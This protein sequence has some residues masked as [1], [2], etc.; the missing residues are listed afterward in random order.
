[1]TDSD[2]DL[3]LNKYNIAWASVVL[4]ATVVDCEFV[5]VDNISLCDKFLLKK[6]LK[7]KSTTLDILHI[8]PKYIKYNGN[9][10]FA[11]TTCNLSTVS[12]RILQQIIQGKIP[13]KNVDVAQ[14]LVAKNAIN[15]THVSTKWCGVVFKNNEHITLAV[16]LRRHLVAVRDLKDA[17]EILQTFQYLSRSVYIDGDSV[18]ILQE[19]DLA[20]DLHDVSSKLNCARFDSFLVNKDS[21]KYIY[22]PQTF[23]LHN[24]YLFPKYT[25]FTATSLSCFAVLGSL[26]NG[27]VFYQEKRNQALCTNGNNDYSLQN[28]MSLLE[29]QSNKKKMLITL[30]EYKA[31]QSWAQQYS[32]P[33][34]FS[35]FKAAHK[36]QFLHKIA[37][38][39]HGNNLVIIVKL[40]PYAIY[41]NDDKRKT[42]NILQKYSEETSS[43]TKNALAEN[44]DKEF[45]T[46]TEINNQNICL[47]VSLGELS[48]NNQTPAPRSSSQQRTRE[49]AKV[50]RTKYTKITKNCRSKKDK[51]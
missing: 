35:V 14:N 50:L 13:I 10:R 19:K 4:D 12:Q 6:R 51:R 38:E 37:G 48:K 31:T 8:G 32:L 23:F 28:E 34:L 30:S 33:V 36:G 18:T 46:T 29:Q 24:V 2:L 26:Y 5:T 47:N 45:T 20:L 7:Q 49:N 22:H 3:I 1:L 40:S 11:I 25:S 41:K 42:A 9:K 15:D 21:P 17:S 43:M 44:F 27:S 16:Y 39:I